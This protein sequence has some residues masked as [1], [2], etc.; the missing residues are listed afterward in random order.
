MT[1]PED[2]PVGK[3][4]VTFVVQDVDDRRTENSEM[5]YSMV[6]GD[7][8][9]FWI[10]RTTGEGMMMMVVVMVVMMMMMVVVV[11]MILLLLLM[12]MM[13]VVSLS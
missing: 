1:L 13:M 2:V 8:E 10:N 6:A 11:V 12:M 7:S 5:I 9:L 4:L 3:E